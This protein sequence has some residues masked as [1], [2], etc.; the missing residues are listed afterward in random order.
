MNV[1]FN[2]N[3]LGMEGLGAT[4]SSLLQHCS[5]TRQLQLHFLCSDV[6]VTHKKN[7]EK[8][9]AIN[10][11]KGGIHFIDF[12][13]KQTFGHLHSLHGDWTPYGRLLIPEL[14]DAEKVLY[15]DTDLVVL[16]DVLEL[17]HFKYSNFPLAAVNGGRTEQSRD[18]DFYINTL[19][20]EA[21]VR[22]F[23]SGVL[24]FNKKAW[25]AQ[26]VEAKSQLL[27]E[28]Y[29]NRFLS[30]DQTLLNALFKGNFAY[31]P[32]QYNRRW[33]PMDGFITD[34]ENSIIHFVGSPKPW[35]VFGRKLHQ[36]YDLWNAYNPDFWA[37]TYNRMSRDK[38][39]R[40]WKI[41]K[42]VARGMINAIK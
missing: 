12:D 26:Q 11:F 41:K 13:A 15:L 29:G 21:N 30:A 19:D 33:S 4:L 7:I 20:F 28:T 34:T 36:A 17:R 2:I 22:V 35:D 14:I 31:L 40:T 23:N 5:D 8:L 32:Q 42:S 39:Y 1:A 3:L 25:K 24:L 6:P 9:A 27:C 38:L 37:S 16:L 10:D 18:A